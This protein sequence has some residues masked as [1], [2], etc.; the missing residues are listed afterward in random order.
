MQAQ[1]LPKALENSP[2]CLDIPSVLSG[3]GPQT[4]QKP[5][6]GS[7]SGEWGQ[8]LPLQGLVHKGTSRQRPYTRRPLLCPASPHLVQHW[9]VQLLLLDAQ[10][11][12]PGQELLGLDEEAGA[13]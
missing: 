8:S 5:P 2:P 9:L 13:Q 12:D 10:T 6:V 11:A 4:S 7:L 1:E 3:S